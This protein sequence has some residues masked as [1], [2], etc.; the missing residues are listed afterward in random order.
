M[1][2]D[3]IGLDL[4]AVLLLGIS[5]SEANFVGIAMIFMM[6]FLL[7]IGTVAFKRRS[8]LF[9]HLL[10][11]SP[12]AEAFLTG[13]CDYSLRVLLFLGGE[14]GTLGSLHMLFRMI[15]PW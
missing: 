15:S 4:C 13:L 7:H 14:G 1:F 5:G 12:N 8:E 3:D 10:H 9:Y 6:Y 11:F 2:I